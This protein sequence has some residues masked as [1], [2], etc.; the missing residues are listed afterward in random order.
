[1]P[2]ATFEDGG[3]VSKTLAFLWKIKAIA[4]LQIFLNCIFSGTFR[5]QYNAHACSQPIYYFYWII[6]RLFIRHQSNEKDTRDWMTEGQSAIH[7]Y[8]QLM[9]PESQWC[10][11][12]EII[13]STVFIGLKF[14]SWKIVIHCL[15]NCQNFVYLCVGRRGGG[16]C[17]GSA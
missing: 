16:K 15:W 5:L 3:S 8:S 1:M 10:F 6:C 12:I 4:W 9:Q 11:G 7:N 14:W 17:K 13:N 2:C